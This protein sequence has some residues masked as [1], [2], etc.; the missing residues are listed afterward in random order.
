MSEIQAWSFLVSRNQF[1]DYRTIVAPDFMCQANIASLL[2]KAAEGNPVANNLAYYREIYGSKSGDLTIIYQVHEAQAKDIKDDTEGILKDSFGREIYLIEGIVLKGVKLF[3]EITTEI[4]DSNHQKL[5]GNFRDFWEWVSPQRAIPSEYTVLNLTDGIILKKNILSPHVL[6]NKAYDLTPPPTT[7]ESGLDKFNK[8]FKAL[9]FPEEIRQCF[10]INN[11]EILVFLDVRL[12]IHHDRKV[13]LID[14]ESGNKTELLHGKLGLRAI[15]FIYFSF[16]K[17]MLVSSN[18]SLIGKDESSKH[19]ARGVAICPYFINIYQFSSKSESTIYQ[20]GGEMLALSKDSKWIICAAH[21]SLNPELVDINKGTN[22]TLSGGHE[23]KI[24]C[25]D[26][27]ILDNVFASGDSSGFI[28]LWNCDVLETI[29]GLPVFQNHIDAIAFNPTRKVLFCS[30]DEGVIK[31]VTYKDEVNSHSEAK[32]NSHTG[33]KG[34][35]TKVNALAINS[36]GKILASG[37]DD[38]SIRLWDIQ[39]GEKQNGYLLSGH[40]EPLTSLSFSPN[41][42]LLISGGKDKTVKIWQLDEVMLKQQ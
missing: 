23:K 33:I 30:G 29:G 36:D 1:L 8:P 10:F 34:K 42:K 16:D 21:N 18:R 26:S 24:T 6:G 4:L 35:K 32:F 37:G 19:P 13:L 3:L 27:S 22:K 14:T 9:D 25:L 17:N 12:W 7:E 5:L 40:D 20:G 41:G 15:E 39:K 28:R 31:T 11:T 2:A 38:G